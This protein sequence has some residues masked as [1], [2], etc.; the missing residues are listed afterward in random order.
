MPTHSV[1]LQNIRLVEGKI[2]PSHPSH[3][4]ALWEM[5]VGGNGGVK[6][7]TVRRVKVFPVRI[8][9]R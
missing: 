3:P 1:S 9:K 8:Q 6:G 2:S 7:P 4:L 5:D